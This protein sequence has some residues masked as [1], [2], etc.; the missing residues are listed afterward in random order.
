M[1]GQTHKNA[2][3]LKKKRIHIKLSYG[4]QTMRL[5]YKERLEEN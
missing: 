3:A 4:R 5:P 1:E 2:G